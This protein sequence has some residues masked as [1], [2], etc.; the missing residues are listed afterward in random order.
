MPTYKPELTL[1]EQA[2]YLSIAKELQAAG[3]G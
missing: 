1:R 2:K 3:R